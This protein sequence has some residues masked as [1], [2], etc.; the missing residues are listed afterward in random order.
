PASG[1]LWPGPAW[2]ARPIQ[3]NEVR[4]PSTAAP[5]GPLQ[6]GSGLAIVRALP[7]RRREAWGTV[8]DRRRRRGVAQW[9]AWLATDLRRRRRPVAR[10]EERRP[11]RG[12]AIDRS[13][14]LRRRRPGPA[15]GAT[16]R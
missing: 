9:F 6:P 5:C 16:C 13:L 2:K 1:P 8:L 4:R 12:R 10:G 14:L 3:R 15:A 11:G 7:V